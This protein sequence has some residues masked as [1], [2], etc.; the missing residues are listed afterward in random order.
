MDVEKVRK[1]TK[2]VSEGLVH[3]HHSGCSLPP[4]CV[5]DS[6][7]D[8]IREEAVRG[9]YETQNVKAK[10]LE[11]V[12][13]SIGRLIHADPEEIALTESCTAAWRDCFDFFCRQ[14]ALGEDDIILTA[15]TEYCSNVIAML[16]LRSSKVKVE[17]IPTT[18]PHFDL[19][20]DRLSARLEEDFQGAKKIKMICLT[21]VATSGG[22]VLTCLP[23]IGALAKNYRIPFLLDA[24]QAVGQMRVDVKEIGCDAL[25]A[26]GRKF[27]RGPRGTGFLFLKKDHFQESLHQRSSEFDRDKEPPRLDLNG[28]FW[29]AEGE[30]TFS[31][32][33]PSA[34]QFELW[35][36]SYSLRVG[37]GA[38]VDYLL[39]VGVD[40]VEQRISHLS[41][42]LREK[43]SLEGFHL[44]DAGSKQCALV[45]FTRKETSV[46]ID[47]PFVEKVQEILREKHRI[48]LGTSRREYSLWDFSQ[49]SLT[50][51]W[52]ASVHYFNT[53]TEIDLLV[54]TLS[55]VVSSLL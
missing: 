38:A 45:T 28:A 52:R 42:Y 9:G 41:Q 33:T 4:D 47:Q 44:T 54:S 8:Y 25:A 18:P 5:V 19:D 49:R 34:R 55:S 43:L 27:L 2:G 35:E 14:T 23:W 20:L 6:Q 1:E 29:S 22:Q 11:K 15:H 3:F 13:E 50:H 10:R 32:K 16:Q 36:A 17:K 48:N 21:W 46:P 53:E 7:I 37:L 40:A 26:A 30:Y 39:E 12:Y 31:A 51:V 24:C